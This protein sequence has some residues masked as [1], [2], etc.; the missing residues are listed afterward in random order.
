MRSNPFEIESLFY[1]FQERVTH[2][3]NEHLMAYISEDEIKRAAFS[4][5]GSS[6]PGE[7][8]LT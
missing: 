3:M 1:G 5:K 2:T 6:A 7:N 4:V 8:G